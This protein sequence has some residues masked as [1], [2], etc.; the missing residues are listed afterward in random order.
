MDGDVNKF[1]AWIDRHPRVGWY[2]AVLVTL[3]LLFEVA[4]FF[5]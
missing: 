5:K 1:L 2:I 4:N 3:D